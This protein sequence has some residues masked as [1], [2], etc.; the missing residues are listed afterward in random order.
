MSL[1]GGDLEFGQV[2]GS[3]D[4]L[5]EVNEGLYDWN[6]VLRGAGREEREGRVDS[7]LNQPGNGSE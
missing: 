2:G 3:T 7:T 4:L 6:Y 5:D 1:L